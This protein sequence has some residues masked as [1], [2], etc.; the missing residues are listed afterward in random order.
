MTEVTTQLVD[1]ISS[2]V[3]LS[4][5][6][7]KARPEEII[8]AL[9]TVSLVASVKLQDELSG[10]AAI[11]AARQFRATADVLIDKRG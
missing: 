9:A 11:A 4:A 8:N 6:T 7:D 3:S 10:D 2:V 5:S 1:S